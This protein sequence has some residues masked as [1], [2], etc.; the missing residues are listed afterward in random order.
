[1]KL[2]LI[3]LYFLIAGCTCPQ[4]QSKQDRKRIEIYDKA[5]DIQEHAVIKDDHFTIYDRDLFIFN[6][7]KR[8]KVCCVEFRC[9]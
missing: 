4:V 1:M 5:G 2:T 9:C 6:K 7:T 3:I 8:L